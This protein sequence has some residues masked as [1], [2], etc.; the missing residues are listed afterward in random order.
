MTCSTPPMKIG[1]ASWPAISVGAEPGETRNSFWS[2]SRKTTSPFS[3]SL[4]GPLPVP[5]KVSWVSV[6]PAP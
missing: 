4:T 5:K 1:S 2:A 3:L 6:P